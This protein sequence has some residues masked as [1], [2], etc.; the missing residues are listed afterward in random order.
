[1]NN[2]NN[3]E[4]KKIVTFVPFYGNGNR[5]FYD[6]TF[7]YDDKFIDFQLGLIDRFSRLEQYNFV[8]KCVKTNPQAQ[9]SEII[10]NWIYSKRYSNIIYRDDELKNSLILSDKV[11]IDYPGS[12]VLECEKHKLSTL[13]LYYE[14][15][16][17]RHAALNSLKFIQLRKFQDIG[18]GVEIVERFLLEN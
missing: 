5:R 18:N 4:P 12:A 9:F 6:S 1:M 8:V 16:E 17:I 7:F 11:I 10:K 15:L 2:N 13:V 14:D 3:Y